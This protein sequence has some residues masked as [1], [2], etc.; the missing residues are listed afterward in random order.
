[1]GSMVNSKNATKKEI[2]LFFNTLAGLVKNMEGYYTVVDLRNE[3]CVTGKITRVDAYMN[4]EME[5]VVFYDTRG[6]KK[7]MS[8]FYVCA[9]NIRNVHMPK[10]KDAVDLLKNQLDC[11]T[12]K[13]T[14]AVRTFK[15]SRAIRKNIETVKEAFQDRKPPQ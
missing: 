8:N 3:C 6:R 10:H 4:M 13:K 2:S 5:D 15:I 14:K 11:M 7:S 12:R 9:R 1:M